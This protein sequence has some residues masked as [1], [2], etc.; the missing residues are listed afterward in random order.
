MNCGKNSFYVGLASLCLCACLAGAAPGQKADAKA[1]KDSEP[2]ARQEKT[3]N[4]K[5]DKKASP[6]AE[7]RESAAL[8]LVGAHH[9]ELYGL[10]QQLKSDN[11]KQYQQAILDLYRASRRLSDRKEKD[12][13][14]YELELKAW[15][16]DSQARL[17]AAKLTMEANPE[18]EDQLKAAL[19]EREDVRVGLLELDRTRVAGRLEQL[20]RELDKRRGRRDDDAQKA[21]EQLMRRSGKGRPKNKAAKETQAAARTSKSDAAKPD[22]AKPEPA[23]QEPVNTNP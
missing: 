5:A 4:S 8:A 6:S 19:L 20:D 23:K 17:L 1:A 7:E 18:L 14:R 9:P 21:F 15:K 2:Q 22:A 3:K 16:L 12:P 13:V 10:L 11:P